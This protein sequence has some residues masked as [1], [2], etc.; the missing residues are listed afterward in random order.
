MLSLGCAHSLDGPKVTDTPL[1]ATAAILLEQANGRE[2]LRI[3]VDSSV[4]FPYEIHRLWLTPGQERVETYL[5]FPYQGLQEHRLAAETLKNQCV[6]SIRDSGAELVC[7]AGSR[8][9]LDHGAW[10]L[11]RE[12]EAGL[13]SIAM[14]AHFGSD[15]TNPDGSIT[16]TADG[17]AV[18]VQVS[19]FLTA[20]TATFSQPGTTNCRNDLCQSVSKLLR[21]LGTNLE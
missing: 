18:E 17:T 10:I 15:E 19:P 1:H 13:H 11:A 7:K 8:R 16:I 4:L 14:P 3:W 9:P 20:S 6:G 12:I 2:D 21:Y 5:W